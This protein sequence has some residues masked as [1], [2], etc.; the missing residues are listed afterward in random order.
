MQKEYTQEEIWAIYETLPEELQEA[1]FS[2]KTAEVIFNACADIGGEDGRTSEVGKYAGR[3]LMGEMPVQEFKI[4]L[5]L[6]FNLN[7]EEANSIYTAINEAVFEPLKDSIA[8]IPMARAKKEAEATSESAQEI[9]PL[10]AAEPEYPQ[11]APISEPGELEPAP[12]P[13]PREAQ[14]S[15][16]GPSLENLEEA[17]ERINA[18]ITRQDARQQPE[19]PPAPPA[20][21]GSDGYREPLS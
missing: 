13:D 21:K 9:E 7:H 15:S 19:R 14:G 10:P 5:E 12:I 17:Q 20:P 11:E 18:A 3:V 2:E 8:S 4:S 6:D 1:I 16:E